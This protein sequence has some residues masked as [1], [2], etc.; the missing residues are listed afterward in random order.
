MNRPQPTTGATR[1]VAASVRLLGDDRRRHDRGEL[2]GSVRSPR[3]RATTRPARR[4]A[5]IQAA[6]DRANAAADAFFQAQ[7]DLEVLEDDL[8]RLELR[9]GATSIAQRREA[10]SATSKA[11][12]SGGSSTAAP[13][14][15]PLLTGMQPPKDQVQAEVF[16]D[17]LTNNGSDAMDQ[18]EAAKDDLEQKRAELARPPRGDRGPAGGLHP[19]ARRRPRPRSAASARSKR[20]G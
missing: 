14:G 7:S 6:R 19:A 9:R 4:V 3:R 1:H 20:N 16:V 18:Y 5:E 11:S 8:A 15:I 2:G 17:V 13:A 10:A 12:R